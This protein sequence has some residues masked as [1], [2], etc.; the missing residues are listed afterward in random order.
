MKD[1]PKWINADVPGEGE[2]G[3]I[4]QN[5]AEEEAVKAKTAQFRVTRAAEGTPGLRTYEVVLPVK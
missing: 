1:Y 4:V 2:V 5:A 3:L